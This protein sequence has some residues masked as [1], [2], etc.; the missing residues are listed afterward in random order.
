MRKS[1]ANAEEHAQRGENPRGEEHAKRR[2]LHAFFLVRQVQLANLTV[3][4]NWSVRQ[5]ERICAQPVKPA[6]KPRPR[7]FASLLGRNAL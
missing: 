5:L 2:F 7:L 1:I 4:Q 6:P 3:Q